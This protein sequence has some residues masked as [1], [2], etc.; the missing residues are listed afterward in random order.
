MNTTMTSLS[1][2]PE[3][4]RKPRI[5]GSARRQYIGDYQIDPVALRHFNELRER[6]DLS[7]PPLD[8]DQVA[9]AARELVDQPHPAGAPPCIL[10]RVRRGAAIDMMLADPDWDTD[11]RRANV[12]A[13]VASYMRGN[14]ALIPNQLPVVGRLDDAILVEESWPTLEQEVADYLDFCRLRHIE[15]VL[16]GEERRRRFGFTREQWQDAAAAERAW[17]EHMQRVDTGSYLPS[18]PVRRFRI[19]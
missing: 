10:Q 19:N 14:H 8:R 7:H 6:L 11:A 12:A 16:R 18:G 5:D 17:I 2:L 3:S 4:L 9:S 1:P 15:A 13:I